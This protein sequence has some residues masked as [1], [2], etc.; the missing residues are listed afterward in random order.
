MRGIQLYVN[1]WKIIN[2]SGMWLLPLRGA[3]ATFAETLGLKIKL[4]R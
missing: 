2:F 1:E 4:K 3:C